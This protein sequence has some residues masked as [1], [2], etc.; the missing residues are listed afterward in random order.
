[1]TIQKAMRVRSELKKKAASLLELI[2]S[3]DYN[4]SWEEKEP[5]P[6]QITE[7]RQ[8]KLFALDGMTYAQAA[9][10]FLVIVQACEELNTKI[11]EVNKEGHNLLF[12]ETALK[13]KLSFIEKLLADER[14]I[15]PVEKRKE[16]NYDCCDNAG[17]PAMVEKTVYNYPI[18]DDDCFGM[19][20]VEFREKLN[21]EIEDVRDQLQAFNAT[22]K[23]DFVLPP[24]LM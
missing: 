7:K 23:V 16:A 20:L 14:K 4:I 15:V 18:L 11:E 17:R 3:V 8:E 21:A 1:M 5:T 2:S 6:E 13:S 22:A 12:K 10:K 19:G 9:K 24:E